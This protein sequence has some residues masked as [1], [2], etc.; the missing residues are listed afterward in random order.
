M[1]IEAR[2]EFRD[3]LFALEGSEGDFGFEQRGGRT[4]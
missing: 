3:R 1:D 4:G 2:R